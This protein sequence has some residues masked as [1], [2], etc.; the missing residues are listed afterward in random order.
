MQCAIARRA[1]TINL[2][3]DGEK[4]LAYKYS[5]VLFISLSLQAF[6]DFVDLT[7]PLCR[8]NVRIRIHL[9]YTHHSMH[10]STSIFQRR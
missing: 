4:T 6:V 2:K 3:N 1:S 5:T 7:G 9:P 8:F 10:G